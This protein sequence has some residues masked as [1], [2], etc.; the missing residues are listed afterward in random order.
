VSHNVTQLVKGN[1]AYSLQITSNVKH[2]D[3]VFL[4]NFIL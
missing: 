4:H 1:D 3:E 2:M